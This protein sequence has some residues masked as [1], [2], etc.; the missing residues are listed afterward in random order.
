[1]LGRDGEFAQLAKLLR[2]ACEAQGG[3]LVLRGEAGIGKSTLLE[4]ASRQAP[5]LGMS[6]L[7]ARGTPPESRM[8]FGALHQ[9]LWPLLR[10]DA[11]PVAPRESLRAAF[12]HASMATPDPYGVAFAALDLISEAAS[13]GPILL[14]AEDAHWLDQPTAHVLGFVGQRLRGLPVAMLVAVRDAHDDAFTD[15]GLTEVAIGPLP[16]GAAMALLEQQAYDLPLSVRPRLLEAARGNPLALLELPTAVR[17][18]AETET[19]LGSVLPV[20]FRLERAFAARLPEIPEATRTALLVL[21][22]DNRCTL[23]EVITATTQ[24]HHGD[25]SVAVI[26][27]AATAGLV[28]TDGTAVRFRHPLIASAVYQNASL[29]QRM[30]VHTTL[31]GILTADPDRSVWHRATAALGPD[32]AAA[33]DLAGFAQRAVTRGAVAVAADALERAAALTADPAEGPDLLLH[34]AKLACEI[35][36]G[37]G[38]ALTL[39]DRIPPGTLDVRGQARRALVE[40]VAGCHPDNDVTL[41]RPLVDHAMR[42]WQD[43]DQELAYALTAAAAL[44]CWMNDAP[45]ELRMWIAESLER[46]DPQLRHPGTLHGM[47]YLLPLERGRVLAH[48]AAQLHAAANAG[49]RARHISVVQGMLGEWATAVQGLTAAVADMRARGRATMVARYLGLWTAADIWIGE[50]DR[51]LAHGLEAEQLASATNDPAWRLF[52]LGYQTWIAA[53]R[54]KAEQAEALAAQILSDPHATPYLRSAAHRG[55]GISALNAGRPQEAFDRLARLF[56]PADPAHHYGLILHTLDDLADAARGCGRTSDARAII[57]RLDPEIASTAA[58]PFQ[59][60]LYYARAVLADDQDA[61]PLLS[62]ALAAELPPWPYHRARLYLAYGK[63]LRRQRRHVESRAPLHLALDTFDRLGA[64]HWSAEARGELRAT[65]EPC[66][67]HSQG[68]PGLSAQELRIAQMAARGLSNRQIGQH[69]MLSHRT[70]GAH[71]YR[72]FPKLGITSRGQLAAI[73]AER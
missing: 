1:M 36:G 48:R 57:A 6:V 27:P 59:A 65:G 17:H 15:S 33:A 72:I 26:E 32:P 13:T 52:A 10:D 21:A 47:A 31:A 29:T 3:A 25:V 20:T 71:L 14:T 34:A 73:L 45:A 12:G 63:W 61:G 22:A 18:C 68:L 69:L 8:P 70:I 53:L 58:T 35:P 11:M 9:L 23:G 44:R 2:S 38:R 41:V 67:G 39:I 50:W 62:A 54:G 49:V 60:G 55:L 5:E 56:D 37:K 28:R 30:A 51:A 19:S 40:D 24:I 46:L 64:R 66:P 4:A 42:A 16:D 43:G 7:G